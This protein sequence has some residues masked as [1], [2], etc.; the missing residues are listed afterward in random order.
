MAFNKD[1]RS[2]P[3]FGLFAHRLLE[4]VCTEYSLNLGEVWAKVSDKTVVQLRKTHRR[5]QRRADPL[6]K[7]KK[8]RSA[9][10]YFTAHQRKSV[11]KSNPKATFGDI[12]KL[13]SA[14]WKKM[15]DKQKGKYVKLATA[16]KVRYQ[17]ECAEV[18][19]AA[20][21]PP[22]LPPAP[23]VKKPLTA[24]FLYQQDVRSKIK[25]KNPS[26]KPPQ[27]AKEASRLWKKLTTKQ[28][29]KYEKLASADR[30]RYQLEKAAAEEAAA[31]L[32]AQSQ[33]GGNNVVAPAAVA[34]Q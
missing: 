24:F 15:S 25:T 12:S 3:E 26:M 1:F 2:N 30:T 8:N 18:R 9:Y 22:V 21:L 20:G 27:V 23:R 6:S 7:V 29:S 11:V 34:A 33:S 5:N 14:K 19:A 32:A 17:T 16:D 28:R 10:S 31:A 4:F 13:I